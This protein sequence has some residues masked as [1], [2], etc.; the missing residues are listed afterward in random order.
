MELS[1]EQK[2]TILKELAVLCKDAKQARNDNNYDKLDT[3]LNTINGVIDKYIPDVA[4]EFKR[5]CKN[6]TW[7]LFTYGTNTKDPYQLDDKQIVVLWSGGYDS[8]ALLHALAIKYPDK[9]ITA[10]SFYVDR[11]SN[12][13]RDARARQRIKQIFKEQQIN[14]VSFVECA[15]KIRHVDNGYGLGQPPIWLM[16]IGMALY[17]SDKAICLGYIKE[18][19]LWHYIQYFKEAFNGMKY[20]LDSSNS[21]LFFP[22]E[23][24]NKMKVLSYLKA[25]KLLEACSTCEYE[26][27]NATEPC[28]NCISCKKYEHALQ[29]LEIY[30]QRMA[31]LEKEPLV[32]E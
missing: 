24:T 26:N 20:I 16:G 15:L 19:D 17:G 28:H 7:E 12:K 4:D 22:L 14:N 8:T 25:A 29:E 18:D 30:E 23:W 6:K 13:K 32:E 9:R 11:I 5:E 31:E 3:T 21:E 27:D 2:E 1:E 10:L